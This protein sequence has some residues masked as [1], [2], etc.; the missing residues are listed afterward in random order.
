[1]ANYFLNSKLSERYYFGGGKNGIV[2]F[3]PFTFVGMPEVEAIVDKAT[4][5]LK[6]MSGGAVVNLDC[7]SG[8]HAMMCALLSTTNPGDAVMTV[9]PDDGGHFATRGILE[10]VGRKQFFATYDVKKMRFDAIACGKT[11]RE[12]NA[13]VFYID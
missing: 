7:L 4:K 13:K 12:N 10:R 8:V 2:D 11:F 3:N 5:A 6:E 1:T 9:N